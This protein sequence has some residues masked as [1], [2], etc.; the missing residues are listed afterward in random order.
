[1]EKLIQ[2]TE[3]DLLKIENLGNRSLNEIIGKLSLWGLKLKGSANDARINEKETKHQERDEQATLLDL[4]LSERPK[5]CLQSAGI[6]TLEQLLE[7]SE[8]DLLKIKNLGGKS[9]AEIIKKLSL[10]GLALRSSSYLKIDPDFLKFLDKC[11]TVLNLVFLFINL[12]FEDLDDTFKIKVRSGFKP[13][14]ILL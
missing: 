1:M 8:V 6:R 14:N 10:N 4:R 13:F 11:T 5:N 2:N 9:L 7:Y 3:Y 12:F